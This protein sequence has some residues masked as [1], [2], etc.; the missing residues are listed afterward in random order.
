MSLFF[1][2]GRKRYRRHCRYSRKYSKKLMPEH[3]GETLL[4]VMGLATIYI[5]FPA[6]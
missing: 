3:M 1:R 4:K 2:P 5:G 6:R